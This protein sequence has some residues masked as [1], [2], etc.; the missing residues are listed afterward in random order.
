MGQKLFSI[1][2]IL[3]PAHSILSGNF[4]TVPIICGGKDVL[5]VNLLNRFGDT[6]DN[7]EAFV[8]LIL[9]K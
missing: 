2:A 9:T 6:I 4:P 7:V 1:A 5:Q 3:G 8:S